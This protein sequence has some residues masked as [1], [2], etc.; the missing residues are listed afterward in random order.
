MGEPDLQAS[1]LSESISELWAIYTKEGRPMQG[2][3]EKRRRD[4]TG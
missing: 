1:Q 3:E 2:V 4:R